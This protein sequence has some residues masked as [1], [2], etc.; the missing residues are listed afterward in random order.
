MKKVL[1]LLVS[2]VLLQTQSWALSGGPQY[3][4]SAASYTGTYAGVLIPESDATLATSSGSASIGLFS[5]EQPS[6]GFATGV[7]IAFVN[8]AVF[9]GT[10]DGILDPRGGELNG[11]INATG[12]QGSTTRQ[13]PVI[14][15]LTLLVTFTT[16][17]IPSTTSGAQGN[18]TA[19]VANGN[20]NTQGTRITGLASLDI[21]FN[22][23]ADG[24]PD[25]V[26]TATFQVDGFK[27]IDPL[28]G[29]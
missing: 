6:K 9:N 26:E 22:I 2:F 1:S 3:G 20:N 10:I 7:V 18:I 17:T 12:R 21:F 11:I 13:V 27:Q 5:L 16:E 8:G 23:S 28:T 25:V 29:L 14:D 19:A 4:G 24:S 15:P